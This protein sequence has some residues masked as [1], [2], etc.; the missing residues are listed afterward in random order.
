[1]LIRILFWLWCCS[2]IHV[3]F[4]YNQRQIGRTLNRDDLEK[5]KHCLLDDMPNTYT[6]TK[7]CAEIMVF[8]EGKCLPYG[9]FR[10]PIGKQCCLQN[11]SHTYK[12]TK[13]YVIHW[14]DSFA[15]HERA[16]DGHIDVYD[17]SNFSEK[18]TNII[19]ILFKIFQ[20]FQR[21]KSRYPDGP[22]MCKHPL[23]FNKWQWF[24]A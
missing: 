1:M 18:Y 15:H 4:K 23:I 5:I 19:Y 11:S 2:L 22:T 24:E 3:G 13:I 14:V 9:I 17:K 6:M 16:R 12:F 10:P 7:R 8:R 20:L 21:T